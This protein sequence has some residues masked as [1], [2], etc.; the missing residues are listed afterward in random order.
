MADLR[1]SSYKA[2]RTKTAPKP[3]NPLTANPNK[4]FSGS[5]G[6]KA[7][8]VTPTGETVITFGTSESGNNSQAETIIV[9]SFAQR[10]KEN[11][12]AIAATIAAREK[13]IGVFSPGS[14]HAATHST[15][16]LPVKKFYSESEKREYVEDPY[17]EQTYAAPKGEYFTK[18]Q[19]NKYERE[20]TSSRIL[21]SEDTTQPKSNIFSPESFYAD[22]HS[23]FNKQNIQ[24]FYSGYNVI[25][26]E[27]PF[28]LKS[29]QL[30]KPSIIPK[31]EFIRMSR[32]YTAFNIL[33][34]KPEQPTKYERYFN[35]AKE[36]YMDKTKPIREKFDTWN[37]KGSEFLTSKG[38]FNTS[39]ID[40][41][42]TKYNQSKTYLLSKDKDFS[43]IGS[44]IGILFNSRYYKE[45]MYKAPQIQL[46]YEKGYQ[47]YIRTKPASFVARTGIFFGLP[48]VLKTIG[49]IGGGIS[50]V[51]G[52]S[53]IADKF[54]K[55][56]SYISKMASGTLKYGL[57]LLYVG[58][59]TLEIGRQPTSYERGYTFGRITS[60]EITPMVFGGAAGA[61]A[62]PRISSY[63][64]SYGRKNVPIEQIS[65]PEAYIENKYPSAPVKEHLFIFKQQKYALKRSFYDWE[66]LP[67]L[68]YSNKYM[69]YHATTEKMLMQ[70]RGSRSEI[71]G[72][73]ISDSVSTN[74]LRLANVPSRR[75]APDLFNPYGV[76]KVA[77][78]YTK[79][80]K[81][82]FPEISGQ[83]YAYIP[84][85]KT[86]IE[87]LIPVGTRLN[88]VAR[89][90][91]FK[92]G[93]TRI[94]I[95]EFAASAKGEFI[96]KEEGIFKVG[97]GSSS[98]YNL[99][100]SSILSAGSFGV[101]SLLS[102]SNKRSSAFSGGFTISLMS[103]PISKTS[104]SSSSSIS[105]SLLSSSS[106]YKKSSRTSRGS[107]VSSLIS[108]ASNPSTPSNPII[109]S[110]SGGSRTSGVK[111]NKPTPSITPYLNFEAMLKE[112][113]NKFKVFDLS[114]T[115]KKTPSLEAVI[116]KKHG[117][118]PKIITG[119]EIRPLGN[120]R[121]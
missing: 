76:P 70:V 101:A 120:L 121:W 9:P 91:S 47:D 53:Y 16:V 63:V 69:G 35:I 79:G 94:A 82:G 118:Y 117:K 31:G 78:I 18:E 116:F 119:L 22:S 83:G 24:P 107:K 19:I 102:R 52:I 25:G 113:K 51:T 23:F 44:G 11:K 68:T 34:P 65:R 115:G 105:R 88:I 55:T 40:E 104:S 62:L 108:I 17:T 72:L 58:S 54:P 100:S 36:F 112:N 90:Y 92:Y 85:Q 30:E 97:G 45:Y 64:Y 66:N 67:E 114:W 59:K 6:T 46:G 73:Y 21:S 8:A 5:T 10:Q 89:E 48:L 80:F 33:N 1:G 110:Y 42:M 96:V 106:R 103:S 49:W 7:K 28:E 4:Y 71:H 50:K 111:S 77:G 29:I 95:D 37:I 57:P 20:Q 60:S 2:F 84:M 39:W 61:Y 109:P 98:S 26:Y 14:Y 38:F 75:Y 13:R 87:A 12:K 43:K 15:N 99:A 74:F 86:E 56:Y 93:G 41:E 32:E 81:L 27:N 3:S